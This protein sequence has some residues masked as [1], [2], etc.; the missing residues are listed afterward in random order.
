MLLD[1]MGR[2]RGGLHRLPPSLLHP[3]AFGQAG[4]LAARGR[5]ILFLKKCSTI[6]NDLVCN[7]KGMVLFSWLPCVCALPLLPGSPASAWLPGKRIPGRDRSRDSRASHHQLLA[8]ASVSHE[9]GASHRGGSSIA[10]AWQ[11]GE[12]VGTG[13][14]ILLAALFSGVTLCHTSSWLRCRPQVHL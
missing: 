11:Q 9:A 2:A 12:E 5:N 6:I 3:L 14:V 4:G 7:S 8:V 10:E 13:G 1:G